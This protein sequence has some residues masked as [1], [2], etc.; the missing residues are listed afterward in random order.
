M[1]EIEKDINRMRQRLNTFLSQK[2]KQSSEYE[3]MRDEALKKSGKNYAKGF[4][5]I[6]L[7]M[8]YFENA[9]ELA[10]STGYTN[11]AINKANL[12]MEDS[13]DCFWK[14][15]CEKLHIS[16]KQLDALTTDC[17]NY[18]IPLDNMLEGRKEKLA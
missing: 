17:D 12:L 1:T 15:L 18:R 8:G 5:L 11:L 2:Q 7:A 13:F 10:E 16:K 4:V 9:L 3:A 14:T 6:S